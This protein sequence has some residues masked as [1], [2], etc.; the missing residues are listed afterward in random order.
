[1]EIKTLKEY[2]AEAIRNRAPIVNVLL[3]ALDQTEYIYDSNFHDRAV[4]VTT[5][6]YRLDQTFNLAYQ[7]ADLVNNCMVGSE[8]LFVENCLI[9]IT[10][11][12]SCTIVPRPFCHYISP[13]LC[14]IGQ[15]SNAI[16]LYLPECLESDWV[17]F[18]RIVLGCIHEKR[19]FIEIKYLNPFSLF[20]RRKNWFFS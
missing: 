19:F 11:Y 14:D 13:V 15:D 2:L 10:P 7:V 12:N 5:K 8:M 9:D 3:R 20:I 4:A 17:L 18:Y 1:M 16:T 6:A